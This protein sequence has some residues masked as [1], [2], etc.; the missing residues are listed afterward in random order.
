MFSASAAFYNV[1]STEEMLGMSRSYRFS[2]FQFFFRKNIYMYDRVI[3]SSAMVRI[4]KLVFVTFSD[5]L[6]IGRD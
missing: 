5:I 2:T 4:W 1:R 3:N 6:R